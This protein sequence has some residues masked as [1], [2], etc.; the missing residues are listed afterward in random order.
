MPF[1]VHVQNFQSIGDVIVEV[2]GLTVITG[3]NNSGKTALIRSIHGAF[4]NARG[5]SFVRQ[6]ESSAQVEVLFSDGRSLVWEKGPKVNRYE[7]DG[8]PL[9]RVGAG[10]PSE[11]GTLG[12]TSIEAAGRELWPQF[13]QQFVGQI[14][15]LNEPG[16]VLAEAIANVDKVGVL[17]EALRFS[18]TDRRS[19]QAELKLRQE[20]VSTQEANLAFFNGLDDIVSKIEMLKTMEAENSKAKAH[21][22]VLS[23]L[24]L[25]WRQVSGEVSHLA[26]VRE[27]F[28][29]ET[30]FETTLRDYQASL[31]SLVKLKAQLASGEA[32][33]SSLSS[34]RSLPVLDSSLHTRVE[35]TNAALVWARD[36]EQR[37][38]K[39]RHERDQASKALDVAQKSN[40]PEL[41]NIQSS[42][43]QLQEL[44]ALSK[45]WRDAVKSVE[46]LKVSNAESLRDYLKSEAELK[47]LFQESG[48]CPFCGVPHENH[49]C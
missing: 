35:R 42:Y 8:A 6:G 43:R 19:A 34:V 31:S 28:K 30:H 9:N 33:V 25:K 48:Q 27:T 26:L 4:T 46:D 38:V 40:L 22:E 44:S 24:A 16:S 17:N 13:A 10:V 45:K 39:A 47:S 18:Q 32:A 2:S 20:D 12:V 1:K 41:T 15:L 5:T 29:V 11:V 36:L 37:L 7:I 14:F 21:L 23:N 3:P 49:S